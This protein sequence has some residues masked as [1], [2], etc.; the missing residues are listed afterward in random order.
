MSA[1][2]RDGKSSGLR[3]RAE[4]EVAK[5]KA[6]GLKKWKGD[7][8]ALI[9]ELEV[10][11]VELEMQND[12]LHR[13]QVVIEESRS[14][15]ADL[16]DF[17]PVAYLTFD[18]RGLIVEANFK[19]AELLGVE[20]GAL[21]RGLFSL[22]LS[23]PYK[24]PFWEHLRAALFQPGRHASLLQVIRKDGATLDVR[25]ESQGGNDN[26]G[27]LTQVR[28]VLWDTTEQKRREDE[29]RRLNAELE[30]K[31]LQRTAGLQAANRELSLK[32]ADLEEKISGLQRAQEELQLRERDLRE[33]E[34]ALRRAN[35]ELERRVEERTGDL[36]VTNKL[37]EEQKELFQT[38]VDH[39]PVILF[40]YDSS[41]TV[42]MVNRYFQ[43]LLGWSLPEIKKIDLWS[44]MYPD[45]EYRKEALQFMNQ[46]VPGWREFKA[47]TRDGKEINTTWG[48][49]RFSGDRRIA[50]GI[51]LSEQVR[52][53]QRIQQMEKMEA[54]G[55]LAGGIVHDFN[56]LLSVIS[57]N[58]ETALMDMEEESALRHPLLLALAAAKRGNELV[59][60]IIAFSRQKAKNREPMKMSLAL[61]EGL[62]FLHN[63]LPT[64]IKVQKDIAAEMDTIVGD[65][66][67]I[68]QVL[69]NLCSNSLY[70]MREN[71][72]V[73]AVK[74]TP[75][76]MDAGKAAK[77]PGLKDGSYLCLTV[78]DTGQGIPPD[79][80]QKI[81][82]P[83]FTTKRPGQGTGMGLAVVQGIVKSYG[84]DITVQS[85]LGRGSAFEV[86]IPRADSEA[87]PRGSAEQML[88]LGNERVLLVEDEEMQ[89]LSLE[90][91]LE[92]LGYQ[93]NSYRNS[94]E[95]LADFEAHPNDYDLVITD[96]TMPQMTG[97]QLAK[98]IL[99]VRPDIPV[100]LCTGFSEVIDAE[101]AKELGIREFIMKPF[102]IAEF[103]ATIRRVLE[104]PPDSPV[105]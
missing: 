67:E 3:G 28:S 104:P 17:A 12:E 83:F 48:N 21:I 40:L 102:G 71:G 46:E 2:K 13:A 77:Y 34:E 59:R 31:V 8:E 80:M 89:L 14:R 90:R 74:L 98:A 70:A 50:I 39:I 5:K 60:Q 29:I 84:G 7:A 22:F 97:V 35:E 30:N 15:Y 69:I 95:A 85:E 100:I 18:K 6:S 38:I 82:D 9:H 11:Q 96:Q 24:D 87:D 63:S 66:A 68:Q 88:S 91:M 62:K 101:E 36:A 4:R 55:A 64:N 57:I 54:L 92:R 37:L 86:F 81:F 20:R 73:L 32:A 52:L 19:A 103:S 25:I 41:G 10:H 79:L 33:T 49:V 105:P 44:A 99:K 43:E 93:A 47:R 78:S 16:Y 75:V 61:E 45:P 1:D 53:R 94:V 27:R 26:A 23:P 72:G 56:N 58:T 76:R 65:P 51:D 42:S